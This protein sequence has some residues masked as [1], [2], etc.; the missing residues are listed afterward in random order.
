MAFYARIFTK[1]VVRV[2]FSDISVHILG[3]FWPVPTA[4]G[5]RAPAASASF[6]YTRPYVR[7]LVV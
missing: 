2:V 5:Y 1:Y 7:T 3:H 6:A 4:G